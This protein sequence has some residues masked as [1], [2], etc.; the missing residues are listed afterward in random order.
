MNMPTFTNIKGFLL[1]CD[2]HCLWD[3]KLNKD[4]NVKL[5]TDKDDVKKLQTR[6]LHYFGHAC[7][8]NPH[9]IPH[10][11]FQGRIKEQRSIESDS[12]RDGSML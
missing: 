5:N 7:H 10:I 9:R 12:S 11:Y 6:P 8:V 4:I 3:C 2:K 1:L